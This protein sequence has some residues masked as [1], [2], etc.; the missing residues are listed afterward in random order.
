ML[1]AGSR[2]GVLLQILEAVIELPL[3]DL[4]DVDHLLRDQVGELEELLIHL[5]QLF[6]LGD[7]LHAV[8]RVLLFSVSIELLR[9]HPAHNERHI[10][11]AVLSKNF[12]RGVAYS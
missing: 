12:Y 2:R 1:F 5:W 9:A 10:I 6:L 8:L 4:L 3:V 11:L 7:L